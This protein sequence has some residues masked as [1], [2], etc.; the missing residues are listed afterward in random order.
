M[1]DERLEEG[2]VRERKGERKKERYCCSL[3]DETVGIKLSNTCLSVHEAFP[4]TSLPAPLHAGE[5]DQSYK[6]VGHDRGG[7]TRASKNPK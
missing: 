5:C 7:G 4:Q 1:K 6:S 3:T 2:G